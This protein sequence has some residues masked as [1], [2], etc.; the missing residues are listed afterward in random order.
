MIAA[1]IYPVLMLWLFVTIFGYQ[2][3]IELFERNYL[4]RSAIIDKMLTLWGIFACSALV[5]ALLRLT[6]R[7]PSATEPGYANRPTPNLQSFP[8]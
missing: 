3:R 2:L 1:L 7:R 6:R 8:S 4:V 5:W